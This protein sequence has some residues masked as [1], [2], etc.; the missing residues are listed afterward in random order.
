HRSRD[1]SP[2][3]VVGELPERRTATSTTRRNGDGSYTTTIYSAPVN[4]RGPDGSMHPIDTALYPVHTD[5]YAWRS[6]ANG[7]QARLKSVAGGDLV[8]LQM[9]GRILRMSAEG[10]SAAPA[11]RSGSQVSYRGAFPG[12]DLLYQVTATGVKETIDLSGPDSPSSY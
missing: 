9:G 7:F 2:V 4:Y 3:P 6:G 5:G 1:K 11:G 12:A 10:A 8:E